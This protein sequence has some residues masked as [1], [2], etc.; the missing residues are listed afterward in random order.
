MIHDEETGPGF[1]NGAAGIALALQM[2][3]TAVPPHC[4]WDACLLIA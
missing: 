1:L 2:P 4:A 3:A